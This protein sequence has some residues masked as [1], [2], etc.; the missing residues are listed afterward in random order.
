MYPEVGLYCH[1]YPQ[2]GFAVPRGSRGPGLHLICL[3][4]ALA[5]PPL[6]WPISR[7]VAHCFSPMCLCLQ[8]FFLFQLVSSLRASGCNRCLMWSQLRKFLW[9]SSGANLP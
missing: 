5:L 2:D 3:L 7:L 1:R 8:G 9:T 4:G 6:Q